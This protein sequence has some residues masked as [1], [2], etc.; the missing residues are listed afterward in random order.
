MPPLPHTTISPSIH[1]LLVTGTIGIDTVETPTARVEHVLGGSASY[2]AAAASRLAPVRLVGVVGEDFPAQHRL[3]L[4][5][6]GQVDLLG[7]E[8]RKGGKT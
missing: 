1:S 8:T 7:L 6:L 5:S 3:Q 4:E 2:F